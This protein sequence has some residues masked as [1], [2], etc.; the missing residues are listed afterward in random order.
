MNIRFD[1]PGYHLLNIQYHGDSISGSTIP[2]LPHYKMS[3]KEY[4]VLHDQVY[5]LLK[6][7]HIQHSSS[8][9]AIPD[10]LTPK[11]DGMWSMWVDS[12]AINKITIKYCFPIPQISDLLDQLGEAKVFSK[13][14]LRSSYHPIQ[15]QPGNEWKIEF[16]TN[17]GFLVASHAL[18]TLKCVKHLHEVNESGPPTFP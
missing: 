8:P 1:L 5:N 10:L 6:K 4:E 7:G 3:P 12:Q 14:E 18:W 17:E 2:N 9:C 11:K 13:V 15:I 16:K